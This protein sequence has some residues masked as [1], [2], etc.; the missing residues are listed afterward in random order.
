MYR[1]CELR[2]KF[3]IGRRDEKVIAAKSNRNT[4]ARE[5]PI[6]R[7]LQTQINKLGL[8]K[9]LFYS[10]PMTLLNVKITPFFLNISLNKDPF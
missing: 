8:L 1:I 6:I 7:Q 4:L 9:V 10:L 5:L 2:E 3:L